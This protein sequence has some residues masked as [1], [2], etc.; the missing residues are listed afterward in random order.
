MHTSTI[1]A[2]HRT[3]EDL[4]R[5]IHEQ[6]QR[7]AALTW[8][9]DLAMLSQ[10]GVR[11]AIAQLDPDQYTVVF[12]DVNRLK[13][14]NSATGS[15]VQTNRYLRDGFRVRRGELAG[16]YLGDEFLFILPGDADAAGFCSRITRQLA[17]QPLSQ[18]ERMALEAF[19]GLGARLSATF[20]WEVTSD[21]WATVERLSRDVLALKA[22]R[23]TKEARS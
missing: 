11:D 13:A 8:N 23:D 7:I 1:V 5:L 9:D 6:E 18:A 3:T 10:A 14:I 17:S 15:H 21:V 22:R 2:R 19:D 16:Q 4:I 12:A 20:A